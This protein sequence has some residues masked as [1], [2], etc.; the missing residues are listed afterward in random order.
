MSKLDYGVW[1]Y[2]VPA[3]RKSVYNTLRRRT[4]RVAIAMSWSVYLVPWGVKD[5]IDGI[6]DEANKLP[7]GSPVAV[8]DRITSS[9]LK[10]D[11][12]EKDTLNEVARSGLRDILSKAKRLLTQ[13]TRRIREEL[14]KSEDYAE[15]IGGTKAAYRGAAKALEEAEELALVFHLGDNM[16]AAFLSY[17]KSLDAQHAM[18]K[19][20]D[21]DAE[22]KRKHDEKKAK[23]QKVKA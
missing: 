8:R 12:S 1:N 15:A 10:F 22:S 16:E 7:D 2:D 23:K 17:R 14:T 9:V 11:N 20:L 18:I 19:A 13:R 6:V 21:K 4:K 5:Q 3:H